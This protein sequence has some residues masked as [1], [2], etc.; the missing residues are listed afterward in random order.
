MIDWYF[1]ALTYQSS[2]GVDFCWGALENLLYLQ[3]SGIDI[4]FTELRYNNLMAD[5]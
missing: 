4:D 1:K 3:R 5:S 2:G